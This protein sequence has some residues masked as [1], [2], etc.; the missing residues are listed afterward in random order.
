MAEL[1][2]ALHMRIVYIIASPTWG[3]GEQYVFDLTRHMQAG[4]GVQPFFLFPPHSSEAMIARF[5]QI[6]ECR[7]FP[8]AS[9]LWRFMPLA[10][11]R[12]AQLMDEWQADILHINSRQTYFTAVTAKRYTR[13]PFRLI[14]T[15]HLVRAA[16]NS[17]LWRWIYRRI[18]TLE[19]VSECVHRVYLAPFDGEKV[20]PDVR[21]IYNSVPVSQEEAVQPKPDTLPTLLFH[22]R[23]C[24]EKGIEP[25]FEALAMMADLPFRM[26]FAG[27]IGKKDQDLWDRLMAKTP[28]KDKIEYIGFTPDMHS[29]LSRCHIG[30]SP[31]IVREAGPLAMIEHMAY[32]LAVV[33]SNN[34]SQPELIHDGE[35]GLLCPSNDVQALAAALRRVLTDNELRNRLGKQA[36]HDFFE[37]HTYDQFV[38][39]MFNIYSENHL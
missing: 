2:R 21:V 15:Q 13:R 31:S 8:Y 33:T 5:E 14:A 17:P 6:G 7:I 28:M 32:G 30:V 37:H 10:G 23:I 24:R 19:C 18:D 26:I 38:Q 4:H 20:F 22:G 9:K 12:L 16:K 1:E 11:K 35:N 39:E 3:G 34:G 36:Q 27:N 25:L 29:L